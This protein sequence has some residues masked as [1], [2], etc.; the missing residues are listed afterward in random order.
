MAL[1]CSEASTRFILPTWSNA[2][3]PLG[4]DA[5]RVVELGITPKVTT[6]ILHASSGAGQVG[7]GVAAAPAECFRSAVLALADGG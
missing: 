3:T 5:R 7:A 4:V 1:I 6:G 2:G